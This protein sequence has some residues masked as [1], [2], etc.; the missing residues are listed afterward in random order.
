MPSEEDRVLPPKIDEGEATAPKDGRNVPLK[1]PERKKEDVEAFFSFLYTNLA[2]P[3]AIASKDRL[4][5]DEGS[6]VVEVA[7]PEWVGDD[8]DLLQTVMSAY[9]SDGKPQ[10]QNKRLPTMTSAE[11]FD[12]YKDMHASHEQVASWSTFTRTWNRWQGVLTVRPTTQHSRCDDCA[13]YSF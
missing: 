3:V 11:L 4:A 7:L 13:K 1:R 10:L 6:N 9:E 5:E 12:L 2:E 8:H